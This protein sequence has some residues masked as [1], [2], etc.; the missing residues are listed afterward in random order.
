MEVY[1]SFV[2]F[3]DSNQYHWIRSFD[4]N[5]D[6]WESFHNAL[7]Y[8]WQVINILKIFLHIFFF[9]GPLSLI[10]KFR[11]W[12]YFII[13]IFKKIKKWQT[14]YVENIMMFGNES[15]KENKSWYNEINITILLSFWLPFLKTI[16]EKVFEYL[17]VR[18]T[19]YQYNI[20]AG[21][22]FHI[23]FH[24][25]SLSTYLFFRNSLRPCYVSIDRWTSKHI[26]CQGFT[27]V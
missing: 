24:F 14:A 16:W 22:V 26:C 21:N 18:D 25:R 17:I 5:D 3:Y 11:Q 27:W 6:G 23:C 8:Q 7:C 4:P 13:I 20:A 19:Q 2:L 10:L 15:R 9:S 1:G 12:W